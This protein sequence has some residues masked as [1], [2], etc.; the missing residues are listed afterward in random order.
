MLFEQGYCIQGLLVWRT[1][2][3]LTF[4]D[5]NYFKCNAIFR[6]APYLPVFVQVD[7]WRDIACVYDR[8]HRLGR[9]HLP[10]R[11]HLVSLHYFLWLRKRCCCFYWKATYKVTYHNVSLLPTCIYIHYTRCF[12]KISNF[13]K[14]A[15]WL[16]FFIR[17]WWIFT[18]GPSSLTLLTVS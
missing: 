11:K 18:L 6:H 15:S 3:Y 5:Q 14:W 2:P 9:K 17:N 12:I 7:T 4:S 13:V 1:F 8:C 10:F 16:V